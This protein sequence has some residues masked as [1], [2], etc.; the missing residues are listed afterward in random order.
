ML[1]D[2]VV[3]LLIVLAGLLLIVYIDASPVVLWLLVDVVDVDV[4]PLVGD[5]DV[6][7]I[8]LLIVGDDVHDEVFLIAVV[9]K[10]DIQH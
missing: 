8:L 10:F 3:V 4:A 5:I 6:V 9:V 1:L 7:D 2:D